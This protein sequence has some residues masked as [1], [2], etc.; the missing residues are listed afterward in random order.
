M[1][2]RALLKCE[3]NKFLVDQAEEQ[4][5]HSWKLSNKKTTFQ[6]AFLC[7]G[8]DADLQES[9]SSTRRQEWCCQRR[10]QAPLLVQ[11]QSRQGSDEHCATAQ[12]K[13]GLPPR[14]S[15]TGLRT[16]QVKSQ[17]EPFIS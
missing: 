16:Q 3:Q 15:G 8:N 10:T 2:P 13:E 1:P 7:S 14:G 9:W 12:G 5:R 4:Q 11:G 17:L 6:G